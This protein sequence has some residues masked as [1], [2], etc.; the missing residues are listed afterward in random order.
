MA[1]KFGTW[2]SYKQLKGTPTVWTAGFG[3]YEMICPAGHYV[4]SLKCTKSYCYQKE[5]LCAEPASDK[6]HV[7]SGRYYSH[8]FTNAATMD[9]MNWLRDRAHSIR[10]RTRTCTGVQPSQM[11]NMQSCGEDG[12]IVGLRCF[13]S[14]CD[15]MQ[16]VCSSLETN[17][18]SSTGEFMS[19]SDSIAELKQLGLYEDTS[20]WEHPPKDGLPSSWKWDGQQLLKADAAAF[21]V[22]VSRRL[23][24]GCLHAVLIAMLASAAGSGHA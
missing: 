9:W 20:S 11:P 22:S 6:W 5:L 4:A 24:A 8:C 7:A 1:A 17:I 14:E 16:L 12:V 13:G 21:M 3:E 18:N 10:G 2:G 19:V 23:S 15:R